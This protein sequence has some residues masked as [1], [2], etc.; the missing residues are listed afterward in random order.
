MP[1]IYRKSGADKTIIKKIKSLLSFLGVK[2]LIFKIVFC[3]LNIILKTRI[4]FLRGVIFEFY[5]EISDIIFYKNKYGEKFGL[6]ASDNI[7][8]QIFINEEFDL[9]KFNKV[10]NFLNHSKKIENL[11]DIGA[12]IGTICIPA[13]KRNLVQKAF[14]VEPVRKNFDLLKINIILN[15]LEDKIKTYNYALSSEDDKNLDIELAQDNS[16]DHRVRLQNLKLNLYNER[17]RSLEQ[18]KSKKF[19]TLFKNLNH[20]KDLVWMDTQGFEPLILAGAQNLI[21]NKIPLVVEFWPYGLKRNNLWDQMRQIIE[22]FKYFADLSNKEVTLKKVNKENL[23]DLFSNW[24]DEKKG[25]PALFT[26][27]LLLHN[28]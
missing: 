8:K 1:K 25:K 18:V 19:D 20:E 3:I 10:I 4:P 14:A 24:D 23:N 26:D 21:D 2:K 16:G 15:G 9:K 7:S 22:K 5:K 28:N 13:L 17:E 6:F 27:L 11:Y 12:N